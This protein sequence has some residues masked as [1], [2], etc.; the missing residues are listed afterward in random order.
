MSTVLSL[1]VTT[2]AESQEHPRLRCAGLFVNKTNYS[3]HHLAKKRPIM[4]LQAIIAASLLQLR[5]CARKY[6]TSLIPRDYVVQ[7]LRQ[8]KADNSQAW[9][10]CYDNLH[11]KPEERVMKF[12]R[13]SDTAVGDVRWTD[14]GWQIVQRRRVKSRWPRCL[15]QN[16]GSQGIHRRP[17]TEWQKKTKKTLRCSV[18]P[19]VP[20]N[21]GGNS[22][23]GQRK[24]V[25]LGSAVCWMSVSLILK[26]VTR[27]RANKTFERLIKI[28]I[29]MSGHKECCTR[30]KGC[31]KHGSILNTLKKFISSI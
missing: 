24:A 10:A 14:T 16:N 2:E 22:R 27:G 19:R 28:L 18:Q 29:L 25:N 17:I 4:Y 11:C 7:F 13:A 9:C 3:S 31:L 12:P 1:I 26:L 8:I 6:S 20:P 5:T 30:K 21:T 23:T 15:Q